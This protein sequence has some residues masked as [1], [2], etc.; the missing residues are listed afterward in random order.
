MTP[1]LP[2][3]L[4]IDFD[5]TI[6]SY[7]DVMRRLVVER[8]LLP[9]DTNPGKKQI[10]DALRRLPDGEKHWQRLQADVYGPLIGEGRLIDGVREFLD[11][12]RR[13]SVAV[14]V[15]SHKT[16]HAAAGDGRTDLREAA[17]GWMR[18]QG[19]FDD[20]GF[21]LS[22]RQVFFESTR[23]EKADRI[24]RS[25]CVV[26]VDDLEETFLEPSFPRGVRKILFGTHRW[27]GGP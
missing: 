17:R 3:V 1:D 22:E 6:I 15:I 16:P 14:V 7:D 9:P 26:F 24:G 8:G 21:G 27:P 13:R 10:R 18:A 23:P 20:S 11:E 5:N 19:F 2:P 4:G 12:C 25:G